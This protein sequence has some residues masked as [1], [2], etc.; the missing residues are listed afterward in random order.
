MNADDVGP[1]G[2]LF[3]QL[4]MAQASAATG[5]PVRYVG[6]SHQIP[7]QT[8]NT[9]L[10]GNQD[11]LV[12]FADEAEMPEF[13]TKSALGF[14]GPVQLH[15]ARDGR[16]RPVWESRQSAVVFDT[17]KWFSDD[18]ERSFLGTSRLCPGRGHAPPTTSGPPL[19]SRPGL[20]PHCPSSQGQRARSHPGSP[21]VAVACV[22][23]STATGARRPPSCPGCGP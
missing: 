4:A 21:A 15:A 7:F 9:K 22:V 2:I 10:P 18:L 8:Q 1:N 11:L 20:L 14:G 13:V 6:T 5:I 19:R 12:A 3:A 17:N 16:N 23:L